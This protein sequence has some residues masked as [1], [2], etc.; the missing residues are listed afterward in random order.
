MFF[1]LV[2]GSNSPVRVW[3]TRAETLSVT[4]KAKPAELTALQHQQS[5]CR[6]AASP[7]LTPRAFCVDLIL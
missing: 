4:S 5:E 1:L 2:E 3:W 7:V 6:L